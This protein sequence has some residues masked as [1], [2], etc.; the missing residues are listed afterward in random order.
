MHEG[1]VLT[2]EMRGAWRPV[3]HELL[4]RLGPVPPRWRYMVLGEH[5]VLVDAGWRIRDVLHFEVGF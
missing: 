4:E 3:P 2:P 5:V 1:F